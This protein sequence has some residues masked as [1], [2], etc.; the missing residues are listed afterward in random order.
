MM[1]EEQDGDVR[2]AKAGT[3]PAAQGG[4]EMDEEG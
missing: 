2:I 3:P 1:F 4:A